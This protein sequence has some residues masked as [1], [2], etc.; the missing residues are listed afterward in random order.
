M[1][2]I[3]QRPGSA[4]PRSAAVRIRHSKQI[5]I[6]IA[7]EALVVSLRRFEPDGSGEHSNPSHSARFFLCSSRA[8]G[9]CVASVCCHSNRTTFHYYLGTLSPTLPFTVTQ[10]PTLWSSPVFA[11]PM[12]KQA[13]PGAMPAGLGHQQH[14]LSRLDCRCPDR[15]WACVAKRS[16]SATRM[17]GRAYSATIQKGSLTVLT[18]SAPAT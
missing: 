10:V 17:S 16:E 3:P 8:P 12:P 1:F 14:A 15:S 4:S 18:P 11:T 7:I 13:T 2:P 9:S 5:P 6:Q